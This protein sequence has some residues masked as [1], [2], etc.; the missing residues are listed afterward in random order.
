MWPQIH[1]DALKADERAPPGRAARRLRSHFARTSRPISVPVADVDTKGRFQITAW[2]HRT[3]DV[4]YD[5]LGGRDLLSSNWERLSGR[6][7]V[8]REHWCYVGRGGWTRVWLPC[9]LAL[10]RSLAEYHPKCIIICLVPWPSGSPDQV[11]EIGQY[12]LKYTHFI[13]FD[14]RHNFISQSQWIL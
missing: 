12:Y 7:F 3:G 1:T 13:L 14:S 6:C 11:E 9:V 8:S 2:V 5:S 4:N 10:V